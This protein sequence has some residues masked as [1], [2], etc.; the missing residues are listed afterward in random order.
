MPNSSFSSWK[1]SW[2]GH[3]KGKEA[4]ATSGKSNFTSEDSKSD[5]LSQTI[6]TLSRKSPDFGSEKEVFQKGERTLESFTLIDNRDVIRVCMT[7]IHPIPSNHVTR[8]FSFLSSEWKQSAG[9]NTHG[10]YTNLSIPSTLT[11]VCVNHSVSEFL[12]A[13]PLREKGR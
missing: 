13:A 8:L 4:P 3:S 2:T 7:T 12:S 6:I 9:S 11:I 5:T 1:E 10:N